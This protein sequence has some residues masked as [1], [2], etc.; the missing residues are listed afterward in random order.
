M[1]RRLLPLVVLATLLGSCQKDVIEPSNAQAGY[2]GYNAAELLRNVT[3]NVMV[4]N[5]QD[6]NQQAGTLATAIADLQAAPSAATLTAA[7]QAYL[8]ARLPW[9]S[10]EAFAFGPVA[11]QGLDEVIDTWPLNQVDLRNVLGSSA[12]LTPAALRTLDGGLQGFHPIEYLLFGADGQKPLAAITTREY[13]F[14]S[15]TAQN[16]HAATGQLLTAWLPTGGNFAAQL[17]TAGPGNARYPSQKAAVQELVNG[18]IS[19]ADELGNSKIERPLAQQSTELEEGRF[20]DSSKGDFAANLRGIENVYLGR[21]G[22][23]APGVGVAALVA[24]RKPSLDTRFRQ[25]LSAALAAVAA[26][27]GTFGKAIT[28]NPTAIQ[29]AQAKVRTVQN[30]LQNEVLP[31]ANAL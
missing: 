9:E 25:E 8:T 5:L 17:A 31:L 4:A 26:I 21:Y 28:Q 18:L 22:T 6:L 1:I 23:A 7:R 15:A 24:S 20:S 27:P 30:T 10:T 14:L 29:A 12:A 3:A 16:L 2:T 11:T 19:P 13:Q